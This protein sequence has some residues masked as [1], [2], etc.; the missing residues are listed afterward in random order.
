MTDKTDKVTAEKYEA[1][2]GTDSLQ[3]KYFAILRDRTA[4]CRKCAQQQVGSE[5]LAG[6]GGVQ[7]LQRGN[8]TRPGLVIETDSRYCMICGKK[9]KWDRW[10]GEF[11]N[12]NSA[13]PLPVS[14][15]NRIL[16]HYHYVDSIEQRERQRHELVIDHRFPMERWGTDEENNPVDMSEEEIQN[17]FQLLKKDQAGNHNLLKSRACEYCKKTGERGCPMGIRFF[18]AGTD[19]WPDDCPKSGVDAERGCIGCGWYDFAAWRKA[20]NEKIQGG[21]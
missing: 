17:K 12:S 18:Y 5:Q 7:G 9:T 4:H 14:L 13:S 15:Q 19:R 10:T 21:K 2:L 16:E 11:Q 6:G 8:K 3:S 20:L 1:L